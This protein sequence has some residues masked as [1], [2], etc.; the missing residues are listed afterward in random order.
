M[1]LFIIMILAKYCNLVY[2]YILVFISIFLLFSLF[3]YRFSIIFFSYTKITFCLSILFKIEYT[4]HDI[5]MIPDN[6]VVNP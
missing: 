5:P 3:F 2:G 4:R 6:K 1:T